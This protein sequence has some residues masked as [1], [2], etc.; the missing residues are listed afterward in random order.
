[1]VVAVA[2]VRAG[3]T[4]LVPSA[5]GGVAGAAVQAARIA[6][7]RVIASVGSPEKIE[8]VRALGADVVFSTARRLWPTPSAMRPAGA[9]STP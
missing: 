4:V 5:S 3:E 8:A 7:A 6:G 2:A 1:M 9:A